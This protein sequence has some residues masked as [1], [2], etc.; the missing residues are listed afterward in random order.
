MSCDFSLVLE[1]GEKDLEPGDQPTA[2]D[3]NV[4]IGMN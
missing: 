2:D 4:K 3:A 1:S